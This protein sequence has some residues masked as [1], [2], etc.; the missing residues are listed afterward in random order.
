MGLITSSSTLMTAIGRIFGDILEKDITFYLDDSIIASVDFDTHMALLRKVFVRLRQAN[1]KL[2]HKKC[3]FCLS[4]INFPG[5][6]ISESGIVPQ[7]DKV[8]ANSNSKVTKTS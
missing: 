2:G 6:T 8:Q 3:A 4:R 5:N 1:L 7:V